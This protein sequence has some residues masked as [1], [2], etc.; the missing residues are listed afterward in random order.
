MTI[1]AENIGKKFDSRWIFRN[2]DIEITQ[3]SSLALT[4]R[5]GSGKSTLLQILT[6]ALSPSE[7]QVRFGTGENSATEKIGLCAPYID[8]IEEFTLQEHL[9]FHSQFKKP[10]IR[11]QEIIERIGYPHA[12]H[13]PVSG[14]SSGMKQRLKLA[15]VLYFQNEVIALD[16]PTS[17]LDDNGIQ[18]YLAEMDQTKNHKTLIVASNQKIEYEFCAESLFLNQNS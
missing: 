7:G 2:L 8:L 1:K 13:Q 11:H 9:V 18:W 15:L 6:Q 5:N 12:T 16:E 10:L 4:G 14:F 3:G 17:N